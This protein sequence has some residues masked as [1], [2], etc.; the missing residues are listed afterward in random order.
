MQTIPTTAPLAAVKQGNAVAL[1]WR[2]EVNLS[3][4]E[5]RRLAGQ[6]CK[7]QAVLRFARAP[8]YTGRIVGDLRYDRERRAGFAEADLDKDRCPAFAAPWI[9]PRADLLRL[10]R[11][12]R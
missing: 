1:A 9:P 4:Q 11:N 8:F 7:A 2:T 12:P 10:Q 6:Y 5:L 3:A